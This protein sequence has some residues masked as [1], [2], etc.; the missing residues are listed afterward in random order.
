MDDNGC[1]YF[2]DRKNDRIISGGENISPR[3]IEATSI[4]IGV[5]VE[6]G[7]GASN[8]SMNSEASAASDVASNVI[9]SEVLTGPTTRGVD[10]AQS[11]GV[12]I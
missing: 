9:P 5:V 6:R 4:A 7:A 2:V 11:S 12:K 3:D 8:N 10:K 1:L